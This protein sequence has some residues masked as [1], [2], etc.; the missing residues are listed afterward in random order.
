MCFDI[1]PGTYS[2]EHVI[3]MVRRPTTVNECF[4]ARRHWWQKPCIIKKSI[5]LFIYWYFYS[6][7]HSF[8]PHWE[9]L[10][11]EHLIYKEQNDE[12]CFSSHSLFYSVQFIP[13]WFLKHKKTCALFISVLYHERCIQCMYLK[14]TTAFLH[15][16]SYETISTQACFI[17]KATTNASHGMFSWKIQNNNKK[18]TNKRMRKQR[19][20]RGKCLCEWISNFIVAIQYTC[21]HTKGR[22]AI[23]SFIFEVILHQHA[24]KNSLGLMFLIY[25]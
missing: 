5:M 16:T 20:Q 17:S 2:S 13:L 21:I 3:L 10:F 4:W 22:S 8:L 7:K 23:T 12:V 14:K 15:F 19:N 25:I 18:E 9:F 11:L 1:E 24:I 6:Q